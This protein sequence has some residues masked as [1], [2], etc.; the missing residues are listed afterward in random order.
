MSL[1][2][3]AI[4]P[5]RRTLPQVL[6]RVVKVQDT[7][8]RGRKLLRKQAP[9]PAATITEPDHLR[10]TDD[11]LAER[12]EPQARLECLEVP[13]DRH[14]P[15]VLQPRHALAG[16]RAMLPQTGQHAYFDLAPSDL[17]PR[18]AGIGSKWH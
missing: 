14:Q 4:E 18:R 9:Q 12:F 10:R 7:P 5:G 13:Q 3:T 17:A 2:G 15:T 16:P 11:T 6:R 8:R 1:R